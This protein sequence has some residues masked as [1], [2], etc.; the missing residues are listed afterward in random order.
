MKDTSYWQNKFESYLSKTHTA[1]GSH[2]ISHARRVWNLAKSFAS[3]QDDKVTILAACYFHDFV[4][5]PKN[6]PKRTQSSQEAAVRARVVLLEMGFPKDKLND[7]CHCIESHSFSANIEAKTN[8]A[9]VV[10]DADRMEALGA[11]G[12][13]RTFYVAGQ[14]GSKLF[15]SEDPFAQKRE[16][17]DKQF[18]V[19]HFEMKLFKL[20]STMKTLE[21]KKAAEIR[22]EV[23]KRF[24]KDLL[25]ELD[26]KE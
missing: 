9:K 15:C 12:L 8:E 2:D 5:Y 10:Q 16:L 3:D 22:V 6:H 19:D 21:G 17:D 4:S 11:I 23:L 13:A 24:L 7:V 18:A 20:P 25:C 26:I 14:M 1:D